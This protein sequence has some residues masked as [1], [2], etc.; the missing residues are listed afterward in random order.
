MSATGILPT[1]EKKKKQK[2]K[3][4]L[5]PSHCK[6]Y[7]VT[8]I[9]DGEKDFPFWC[10]LPLMTSKNVNNRHKALDRGRFNT[11]D[12]PVW[13]RTCK[14][15]PPDSK[16][17][18][19]MHW[20]DWSCHDGIIKAI[21]HLLRIVLSIHL[22]IYDAGHIA[23]SA[24]WLKIAACWSWCEWRCRTITVWAVKQTS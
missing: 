1:E 17:A 7:V 24:V 8:G 21:Y 4:R 18:Q 13:V 15:L 22:S 11:G 5:E 9:F 10:Q 16:W 3:K 20:F 23:W 2:Q 19:V 14:S 6:P 12:E